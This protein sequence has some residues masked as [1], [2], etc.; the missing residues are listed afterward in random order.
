[1]LRDLIRRSSTIK[2]TLLYAGLFGAAVLVLLGYVYWS[3]TTYMRV[4]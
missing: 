2:L 4:R 1:M 3:P